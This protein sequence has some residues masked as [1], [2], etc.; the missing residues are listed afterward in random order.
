MISCKIAPKLWYKI[1]LVYTLIYDYIL[2][3]NT[4]IKF[5]IISFY[6]IFFKNH[7]LTQKIFYFIIS[8][9]T[10]KIYH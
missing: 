5:L 9:Q 7:Y 2:F 6:S 8:K 10:V 3:Q 1:I 4:C